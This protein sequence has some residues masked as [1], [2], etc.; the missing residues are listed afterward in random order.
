M[1]TPCAALTIARRLS[2]HEFL[3]VADDDAPNVLEPEFA[4]RR[5][6]NLG[7]VFKNYKV[8]LRATISRAVPLLLHR[9]RYIEQTLRIMDAFQPDV[10]MT[11]LEYFVPR[12]AEQAGLPCLTWIISTC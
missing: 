8:D 5:L 3:F 2:G 4:V 6:P 7:T 11:D 1:G 12:A 9:R 10:C